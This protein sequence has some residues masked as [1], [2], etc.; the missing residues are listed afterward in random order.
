MWGPGYAEEMYGGW[1]IATAESDFVTDR[2]VDVSGYTVPEGSVPYSVVPILNSWTLVKDGGIYHIIPSDTGGSGS[3]TAR[4]VADYLVD[5]GTET[6]VLSVIW[7]ISI[8]DVCELF[9]N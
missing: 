2:D 6:L 4:F 8:S 7:T 9:V 3:R 1:G 5:T